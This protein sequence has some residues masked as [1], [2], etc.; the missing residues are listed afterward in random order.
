MQETDTKDVGLIPRL[1]RFPGVGNGNPL[2]YSC[3]EKCHGQKSLAGYSPWGCKELD[4]TEQLSMHN[5]WPARDF[6]IYSFSY[7]FPLWFIIEYQIY[8]SVLYRIQNAIY[9]FYL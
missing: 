7:S 2:Q 6:P 1:G 8:F 5:H 3:L 9:P 4:M